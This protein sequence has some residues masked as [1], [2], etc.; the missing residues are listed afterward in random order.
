MFSHVG[1]NYLSWSE[2]GWGT[3]P[4]G[5]DDNEED[6]GLEEG[7]PYGPPY[8]FQPN[9]FAM[10]PPV[11]GMHPH[12]SLRP[13]LGGFGPQGGAPGGFFR[14]PGHLAPAPA[15]FQ[16]AGS[17]QPNNYQVI[18]CELCSRSPKHSYVVL[19]QPLVKN[20]H[21]CLYFDN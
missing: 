15:P 20:L 18:D 12:P 5:D 10:M 3:P 7:P 4:P 2:G 17:T 11:F 6:M 19:V 13:R 8:P 9:P 14:P 16:P 21:I 1:E